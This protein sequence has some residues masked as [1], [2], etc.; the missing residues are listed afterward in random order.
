VSSNNFEEAAARPDFVHRLRASSPGVH[1]AAVPGENRCL[2]PWC[3][4]VY[5]TIPLGRMEPTRF[6]ASFIALRARRSRS[7]SGTTSMGP[8][9]GRIIRGVLFNAAGMPP[10]GF[11]RMEGVGEGWS[12][13][14][15]N[16]RPIEVW[17]T[18]ASWPLALEIRAS[19][20]SASGM[21]AEELR[22]FCRVVRGQQQVP[23]G[24][25]YADALQV[26]AWMEQLFAAC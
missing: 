24:A 23:A 3:M 25:T 1:R 8:R 15:P 4:T 12:A 21:L 7:G 18:H 13:R 16:P 14:F 19:G 5:A 2:R 22:C 10:R 20:G 26:Q 9:S 11:D 17:D 6:S